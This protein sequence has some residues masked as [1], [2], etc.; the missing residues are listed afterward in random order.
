MSL[1]LLVDPLENLQGPLR[2]PHLLAKELKS[3]VNIIFASPSI[4][5]VVAETLRSEGFEVLSLGRHYYFTGSLLIFEAWLRRSRFCP[6]DDSITINFSQCFLADSH[7]YY[8]QGPITR[9]IDDMRPELKLTYRLIYRLARS[10][11]VKRDNSFNQELRKSSKF[12]IANSRF[13]ATM[14]E[15]WGISVDDIIYPPL[16][17]E[18][19]KP[20]TS[21]P[22]NDY[23][24]TYVGKEAKYFTLKRIADVGVKI[25]AF[26][27]KV[28]YIPK[29]LLKHPNIEFLGRV[30][31][32]E[33]VD[34]Y[35]NALYTLFAFTHEPF[36]YIPVES[37]ACGTPV[38]TYSKQGPN[39]SVLNG[40]TGWTTNY[41]EELV[42]L[43]VKI[44]REGYPSWMKAK[45]R[46]R[47]LEFDVKI[48]ADKWLKII[49]QL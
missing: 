30:S 21:K 38:L 12:F 33:L 16:D 41:D 42:K 19:F 10:F 25:K 18:Q 23:I 49:K 14:Y 24:L 17:C 31:D 32:E 35:S 9:A 5:E 8:A 46:E 2:P 37:M 43:A 3:Y 6:K 27:A 1:L 28:P 39:E 48:I 11:L 47:A 36:G 34:L 7:I 45:C 44:W 13:C 22:S 20:T 26:G 40:A 29:S 15:S 4:N